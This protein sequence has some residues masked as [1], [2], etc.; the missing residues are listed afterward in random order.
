MAATVIGVRKRARG[1]VNLSLFPMH[2]NTVAADLF[3]IKASKS[4]V[5]GF[6]AYGI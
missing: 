3:S 5:Y 2:C 6:V 4:S 1:K